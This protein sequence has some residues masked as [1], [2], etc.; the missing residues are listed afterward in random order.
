MNKER[1]VTEEQAHRLR[2]VGCDLDVVR[3]TEGVRPICYSTDRNDPQWYNSKAWYIPT[4]SQ[5]LKW[6]RVEGVDV[7]V[8]PTI[9]E[10]QRSYVSETMCH[11]Q[12]IESSA[13]EDFEDA[14][15]EAIDNALS[16]IEKS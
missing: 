12:I 2:K 5:A 14:V 7:V 6:L 3:V 11:G 9:N 16:I 1:Y 13:Y 4:Q 15:S 8:K 10:E